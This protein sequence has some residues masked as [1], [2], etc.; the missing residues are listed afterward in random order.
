MFTLRDDDYDM[1]MDNDINTNLIRSNSD[2]TTISESDFVVKEEPSTQPPHPIAVSVPTSVSANQQQLSIP[3]ASYPIDQLH[4]D[5]PTPLQESQQRLES[6]AQSTQLQTQQRHLLPPP[7]PPKPPSSP[8][9][10]H[11]SL[12]QRN[13]KQ[14]NPY[15]YENA[16]YQRILTKNGWEDALV[17]DRNQ[18]IS[19]DHSKDD[20]FE[21]DGWL[22]MSESEKKKALERKQRRILKAQHQQQI[23][24]SYGGALPPSSSDDDINTSSTL[25]Y[26]RRNLL[27][28]SSSDNS[29]GNSSAAV[30]VGR[31]HRD[32]Y[33]Y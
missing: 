15:S 5:P 22:E 7:Q 27:F 28:S 8:P 14:K 21:I 2:A 29:D 16:R 32:L 6:S 10:A 11:R 33:T 3:D 31:D 23:L 12:R 24:Q 1:D 26:K 9:Q 17:K 4:I 13:I 19:Q 18:F 20:D 30:S 25:P